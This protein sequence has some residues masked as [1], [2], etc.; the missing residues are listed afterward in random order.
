MSAVRRLY[1]IVLPVSVHTS[2]SG[3]IKS[4]RQWI[5]LFTEGAKP[6]TKKFNFWNHLNE[7]AQA[8]SQ[9]VSIRFKAYF[10]VIQAAAKKKK[11]IS[12]LLVFQDLLIF[13]F[14]C[15][16]HIFFEVLINQTDAG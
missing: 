15:S 13:F 1:F 5:T 10:C 16:F 6:A 11:K 9:A 8:E 2:V 3:E 14:F 12:S 4:K 7:S